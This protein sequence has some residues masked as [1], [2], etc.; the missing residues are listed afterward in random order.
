MFAVNLAWEISQLNVK[1]GLKVAI[2]DLDLQGGSVST[3]LD[4]PRRESIYELLSDTAA[5]DDESFQAALVNFNEQID[6]LTAPADALPLDILLPEDVDRVLD[7]ALAAYDFVVVDMPTTLVHWTETILQRSDAFFALMEIDMRSA[8]NA[9]RFIRLLKSEDLPI[10]KV[11]YV[12]NRAPKATDLSAR[13]R[14]KRLAENLNINLDIHLPDGG[15]Q[16]TNACDHGLPLLES[17]HKNPLR[18][19]IAKVAG[20]INALATGNAKVK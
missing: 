1:S 18:K 19:E 3:Y 15:K 4:L 7:K 16:V 9:L 5:M 8:Q 11:R 2:L 14:A 13:G 17:A 6:V 20:S 10:E 12:L